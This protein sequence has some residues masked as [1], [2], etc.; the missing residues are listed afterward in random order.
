MPLPL[1]SPVAGPSARSEVRPLA[2]RGRCSASLGIALELARPWPLAIAI[3][4]AIGGTDLVGLTPT[5][6]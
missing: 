2:C 5:G 3:D 4:Y 1:V 6:C